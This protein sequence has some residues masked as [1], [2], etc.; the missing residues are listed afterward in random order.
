MAFF[1]RGKNKLRADNTIIDCYK[2]YVKQT[3]NP[4]NLS[5]SQYISIWKAV[6]SEVVDM[7]IINKFEL[8]LPRRM[9]SLRIKRYKTKFKLKED[10]ELDT[11]KIPVDYPA[12]LKLWEKDPV[13]KENKKLVFILNEHSDN[14]RAFWY[15]DKRT[16]TVKNQSKYAFKAAR[17]NS[18]MLAKAIKEYKIIHY[19]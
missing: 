7:I 17:K 1:G 9:G 6:I 8:F 5:Q 11:R 16:C 13:A 12:T 15:W 19:E 2:Y 14:H 3:G 10:G 4:Y 18:R